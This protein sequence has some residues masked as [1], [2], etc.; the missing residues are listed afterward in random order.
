MKC[1]HISRLKTMR[2]LRIAAPLCILAISLICCSKSDQEMIAAEKVAAYKLLDPDAAKF[3]DVRQIGS[4]VCGEINGKNSFGAYVGFRKFVVLGGDG[5]WNY[6]D[7]QSDDSTEDQ[8]RRCL[9]FMSHLK[10]HNIADFQE[11]CG[12]LDPGF[13]RIYFSSCAKK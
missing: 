4:A 6:A 12:S 2:S 1:W 8:G 3:R 10:E 7:V 13:W 5:K 11:T 9:D